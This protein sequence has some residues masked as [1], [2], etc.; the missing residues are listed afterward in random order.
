MG[1][2]TVKLSQ[3]AGLQRAKSQE[4]GDRLRS[5]HD[6]RKMDKLESL[7]RGGASIRLMVKE[8]GLSA[9]TVAG[10]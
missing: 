1:P 10:W 5:E 2:R 9:T 7:R 6:P 4:R 3:I 8:L